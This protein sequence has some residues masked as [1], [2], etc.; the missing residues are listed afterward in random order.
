[1][2]QCDLTKMN[3][4]IIELTFFA[5]RHLDHCFQINR[6][7]HVLNVE[8]KRRIQPLANLAEQGMD[9]NIIAVSCAEVIDIA[10]KNT[11][12]PHD[13]FDIGAALFFFNH[14]QETR[15][16]QGGNEPPVIGVA[17]HNYKG[18]RVVLIELFAGAD[19]ETYIHKRFALLYAL[20]HNV[21]YRDFGELIEDLPRRG[22]MYVIIKDDFRDFGE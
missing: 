19:S 5:F 14:D 22:G 10:V 11:G 12:I 18:I 6:T 17:G 15:I 9:F 21:F 20:D 7:Q 2:I 16:W 4:F 8:M 13:V 3:I 1:M